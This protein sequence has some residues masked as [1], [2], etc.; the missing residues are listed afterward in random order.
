MN[1]W[2]HCVL[3]GKSIICNEGASEQAPVVDLCLTWSNMIS[4]HPIFEITCKRTVRMS[5]II[6]ASF[7]RLML[8]PTALCLDV[9]NRHIIYLGWGQGELLCGISN[10]SRR[11][12][13]PKVNQVSL[14][15]QHKN[16]SFPNRSTR[17]AHAGKHPRTWLQKTARSDIPQAVFWGEMESKLITQEVLWRSKNKSIRRQFFTLFSVA[18]KTDDPPSLGPASDMSC[19]FLHS[20]SFISHQT[21]SACTGI[22]LPRGCWKEVI[23]QRDL[24]PVWPRGMQ[25]LCSVQV[26]EPFLRLTPPHTHTPTFFIEHWI[27]D[28]QD[29]ALHQSRIFTSG[30]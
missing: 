10:P 5:G 23:L 24:Q 13:F 21:T 18:P 11:S 12:K 19:V 17:A 28:W 15:I 20:S 4:S 9:C 29:L 26:Y 22:D 27:K 1:Y 7:L 6:K 14:Q 3:L 25:A 8:R 30:V 16:C 2:E